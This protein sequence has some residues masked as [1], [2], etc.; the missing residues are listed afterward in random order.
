MAAQVRGGLWEEAPPNVSTEPT[1]TCPCVRDWGQREGAG[2]VLQDLFQGP[3]PRAPCWI[4]SV[5]GGNRR[6]AVLCVA[7]TSPEASPREVRPLKMAW[8]GW[9]GVCQ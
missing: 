7:W 9:S 4:G 5:V 3:D 2:H 8:H 6:E 1:V